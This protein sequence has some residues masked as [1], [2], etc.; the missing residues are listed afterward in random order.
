V[1]VSSGVEQ[2]FGRKDLARV[3]QF[4]RAAKGRSNA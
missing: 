4:I 3:A 1:D 2:S